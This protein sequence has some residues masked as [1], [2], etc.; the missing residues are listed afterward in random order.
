MR[1]RYSA[2]CLA[3]AL[4]LTGCG[5]QRSVDQHAPASGPAAASAPAAVA[6]RGG[7]VEQKAA[8]QASDQPSKITRMNEDGSETV[9]DVPSDSG[10][11][12]PLLAA[13]A[14]TIAVST[15]TASAATVSNS[16]QEGVNYTRIVPAQPTEAPAGQV[17]VLEFFWYACP[18][19][20]ALDPLVESWKRTKPAYITFSRV[21]VL[22]SEGHRSLARLYYTL[23]SMG[24]L[25]QLHAEIF[26][27]IHVNGDPLTAADPNNLVETERIQSAFVRRFGISEADFKSA[28]HSMP[29]DLALQRA[30]EL[31]Q[32]YRVD[33]VPR[34]VVNGKYIADVGSAGTPERLMSL[35]GD[36]AAQEH[37]R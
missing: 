7:A 30:D 13:V 29:V 34:F 17:E 33:A 14:S 18:H 22:W 15:S 4:A 35:V 20:Y 8:E 1:S 24:K 27:E 9:E 32:R 31:V 37:K 2:L 11:H 6:P 36:L 10:V 26:R 25:D 21:H 3:L 16:W 23:E 5:K 12:N 28:Y 19:C